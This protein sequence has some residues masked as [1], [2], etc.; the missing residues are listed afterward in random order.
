MESLIELLKLTLPGGLIL[1]A[2][3]LMVRAFIGKEQKQWHARIQ[4]ERVQV[5]L[6]LR[7]QAYERMC[8]FLERTTVSNLVVRLSET[9]LSAT[10]LHY[11]MLK[12]IRDE[13]NHNFSQQIYLSTEAWKQI[14]AA[15]EE[16]ISLIN[17]SASSLSP[18]AT[19]TEL[20]KQIM[21][22]MSTQKY[23]STAHALDALKEEVSYLF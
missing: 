11:I 18:E 5:S 9:G 15:V 23:D 8:L 17:Q 1:Y 7:L 16:T 12:E 20:V 22:Q 21:Q 2:A 6:P 14:Q 10:Q 3:Y 4:E 13:F 19:H